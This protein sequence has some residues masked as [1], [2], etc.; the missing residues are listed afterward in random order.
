MKKNELVVLFLSLF[1]IFLVILLLFFLNSVFF[2]KNNSRTINEKENVYSL[3]DDYKD[4]TILIITKDGM[5]AYIEAKVNFESNAPEKIIISK[6]LKNEMLN[7]GM[8]VN[9]L[10]EL[11][12][13]NNY[14]NISKVIKAELEKNNYVV[15]NVIIENIELVKNI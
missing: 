2:A 9:N 5:K 1:N 6:N 12:K 15:N 11:I 3:K 13:L 14:K 8:K 7:F 4:L 10:E